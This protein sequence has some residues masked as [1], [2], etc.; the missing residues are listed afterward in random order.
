MSP[1]N[2]GRT[3]THEI[4]HWLN[5]RHIWGDATCGNDQVSDTPTH[6]GYNGGCPAYPHY[7]TC[8]GS[9]V[10]MTMNYMDYTDDACMYMFST[11]QAA[12]MQAALAGPRVSLTTSNGCLP[13]GGGGGSCAVPSGLNATPSA[14]SASLTWTAVSGATSYNL[15]WKPTSGST[16]TTVSSATSP[17][18]LNGLTASTSYQFQVQA[19][20]SS[21]SS[22]YSSPVSFTTTASSGGGGSSCGTPTNLTA[23]P[24]CNSASIS[25][26]TVPGATAYTLQYKLASNTSW[27]SIPNPQTAL[28]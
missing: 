19:V 1:Y 8:S 3:A 13:P 2:K 5:L 24:T 25:W 10:E 11:G 14:T 17:Y 18:T 23:V 20:C 27:T 4:G 28:T 21:G 9:P 12:R 16:W 15:Q 22:A 6:N 26:A 7:S